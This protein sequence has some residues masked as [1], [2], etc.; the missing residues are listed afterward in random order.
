MPSV[1]GDI[2]QMRARRKKLKKKKKKKKNPCKDRALRMGSLS[3]TSR[4]KHLH[5]VTTPFLNP[6]LL[7]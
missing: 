5:S 1:T 2:L 3:K 6:G 7:G 4:R